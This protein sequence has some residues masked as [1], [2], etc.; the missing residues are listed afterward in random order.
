MISLSLVGADLILMGVNELNSAI[1]TRSI[2]EKG[3]SLKGVTRS[4]TEDF[5]TVSKMLNDEYLRSKLEKM[6][7]SKTTI[8]SINDIYN[9]FDLEVENKKDELLNL[10]RKNK[11]NNHNV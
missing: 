7:I 4:S 1:N 11:E 8:N 2:L 3:L 10:A 6:V 5:V 9:V